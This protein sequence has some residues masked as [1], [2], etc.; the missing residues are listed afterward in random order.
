MQRACSVVW[1]LVLG[2][3]GS[4]D[5]PVPFFEAAEQGGPG[6]D[7]T[8]NLDVPTQILEAKCGGSICHGEGGDSA[9]LDL[10]SP[11][12]ESRLIGAATEAGGVCDG[13]L[14]IDPGSPDTSLLYR[15]AVPDLVDCGESMP[16][17]A[18]DL[19]EAEQDCLKVWIREVVAIDLGADVGGTLVDDSVEGAP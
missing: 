8:C 17:G 14:L 9:G 2:C 6:G 4:I 5:D 11:G 16:Y 15:K 3:A 7:L 18:E 1:L 13:E 10:V 19:S 12:I